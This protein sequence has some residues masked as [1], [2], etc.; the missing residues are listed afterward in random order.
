MRNKLDQANINNSD[1]QN[2]PDG[3]I[4]NNTGDGNGTPVNEEVYGD[5]HEMKDKLMRLYGIEHNG[6]PDNE[7]NGYQFVEALKALASKNDFVLPL[8]V[9]DSILRVPLKI[10]KLLPDESFIVK[11]GADK[12]NET[13]IRGIDNVT[14]GVSF[15]GDYKENEYLRIIN[16]AATVVIIRMVDALNLG[17]A[18]DELLYLKGATQTEENAGT[19]DA[20]AT[21]PL[22]NKTVY[23][24]RTIGNDSGNYLAK[25]TGGPDARNGLLSSQDKFKI[26]NFTDPLSQIIIDNQTGVSI[27]NRQP[28]SN[29]NNFNFNY[30]D[31]FPPTGKSITDLKGFICSI[32]EFQYSGN[33]D[34]NDTLFCKY[35]IEATK[36][37]VICGGAEF[38]GNPQINYSAIWI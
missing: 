33:V 15:I 27:T 37:R 19:T 23:I 36:I 11:A 20:K 16:T 8:T 32:A 31:I 22:T 6:L 5:F 17:T 26:D 9:Q 35:R 7:T 4:K 30:V 14:K 34:D 10:G 29:E 12:T 38:D 2:Y 28:G 21:T 13:Q 3:R 25:P 1:P 24:L 18:V